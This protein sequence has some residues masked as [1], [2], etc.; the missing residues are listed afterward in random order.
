[1]AT[2]QIVQSL[3][4]TMQWGQKYCYSVQLMLT[5]RVC[6]CRGSKKLFIFTRISYKN[7]SVTVIKTL[8]NDSN[9]RLLY[10]WDSNLHP[11][12]FNMQNALSGDLGPTHKCG[13]WTQSGPTKCFL[14]ELHKNYKCMTGP[15]R[16]RIFKF[17]HEQFWLGPKP[18][19]EG[20]HSFQFSR[21]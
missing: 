4:T 18:G 3:L 16:T 21:G 13:E 5:P 20:W 17:L 8:G 15:I 10:F 1:M 12:L 9:R 2:L 11:S 7:I 14:L 19:P 6:V